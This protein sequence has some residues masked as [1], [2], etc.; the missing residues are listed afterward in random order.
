MSAARKSAT[1]CPI[2]SVNGSAA[3]KERASSG[4]L[5]STTPYNLFRVYLDVRQSDAVTRFIDRNFAAVRRVERFV[6]VVHTHAGFAVCAVQLHDDLVGKTA[7][8]GEIPPAAVR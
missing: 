3:A 8:V 7:D 5:V 4:Q 6:Y 2:L 1:F